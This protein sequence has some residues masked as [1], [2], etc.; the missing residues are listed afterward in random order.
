MEIRD[1]LEILKKEG[2]EFIKYFEDELG[3]KNQTIDDLID[4]LQ[5]ANNKK[6]GKGS[7]F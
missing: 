4:L 3:Y 6:I 2:I 7:F 5:K 1:I